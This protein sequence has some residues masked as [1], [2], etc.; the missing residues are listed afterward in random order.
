MTI[1]TYSELKSAVA[2][3]LARDDLTSQIPTFIQMAEARLSRTLE[4]RSQE[5]RA[6]AT[7]PANDE[8]ISLPTDLRALRSLRI[9]GTPTRTLEYKSPEDLFS[10]YPNSAT[11]TPQAYTVIGCEIALRPVQTTATEVELIYGES[12]A[13][14]SSGSESGTNTIL[15]RHPDAYLYGALAQAYIFLQ[16]EAK[17]QFYDQALSRSIEEIR[18]DTNKSRYGSGHIAITSNYGA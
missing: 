10:H 13:S 12:I 9:P 3:Y 6:R 7:F 17:A 15:T 5:R 11:G 1:S 8:F 18:D 16:D 4:T 2:S 14:L